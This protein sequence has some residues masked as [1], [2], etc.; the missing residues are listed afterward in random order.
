MPRSRQA[1]NTAI[2]PP[3]LPPHLPES[4]FTPPPIADHASYTQ[5]VIVRCDV[6]EQTADDVLFEQVVLKQVQLGQTLFASAQFIDVRFDACDLAGATWEKAHGQ[7]VE[8]IGC[9]LVGAKLLH[10]DWDN[11]LI[12]DCNAELALFWEGS[13]RATHW[14][15]C[16]LREAS[17]DGANL[18]GVVFRNCD[19]TNAD[20]RNTTL[21]GTDLRGSTLT[22]M[23]VGAKELRGAII[24]PAQA[25]HLARL[26]G[27]TVRALD[28]D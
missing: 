11:V 5:Q 20:L 6:G 14:E 4:P 1:H 15:C 25:V 16:S 7:R 9:R 12:K 22:G 13:F 27:V 2:A 19:L 8:L 10:A 3:Q 28:D 18:A 23:Q 21:R 17:F 26:Q 24:D